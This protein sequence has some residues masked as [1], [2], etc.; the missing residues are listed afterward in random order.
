MYRTVN[1]KSIYKLIA[2]IFPI[3]ISSNTYSQ[4]LRVYFVDHGTTNAILSKPNELLTKINIPVKGRLN[5]QT[6]YSPIRH[7]SLA[8]GWYRHNTLY[9]NIDPAVDSRIE[10]KNTSKI[11]YMKIFCNIVNTYLEL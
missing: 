5:F 1:N 10:Y 3:L 8:L 9:K 4:D 7:L 6:A 11:G 2:L